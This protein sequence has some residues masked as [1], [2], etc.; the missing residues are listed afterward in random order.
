MLRPHGSTDSTDRSD[1]HRA[2]RCLGSRRRGPPDAEAR[3]HARLGAEPPCVNPVNANCVTPPPAYLEKVLEPAFAFAPD[4]TLRPQ[5]VSGA[6]FTKTPPFTVTF[7]IHADARWSDRVPVTARDFVFTH[8]SIVGHLPPESQGVHRLVRS[9]QRVD[10]KTVRVVLR[11]RTADWR[12]PLL[13]RHAVACPQGPR[14]GS[15]LER[16]CREPPDGR[17]HRERPLPSQE[18]GAREGDDPRPEPALLGTAHRLPR[19]DRPPLLP[20]L[21]AAPNP[22]PV[23]CSRV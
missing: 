22:Y 7:S 9:V 17:S 11:S 5:L 10:A 23:L 14:P 20:V 12:T 4:A 8:E 2:T 6:T 13:P 3:R 15:D 1:R 21:P 16:E 18:L 19:A